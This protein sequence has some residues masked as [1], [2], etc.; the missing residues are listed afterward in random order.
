[1]NK[2]R[3]V[4]VSNLGYRRGHEHSV[5]KFVLDLGQV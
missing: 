5:S 3:G 1:M 4:E 2:E